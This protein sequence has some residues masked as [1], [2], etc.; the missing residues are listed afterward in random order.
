MRRFPITIM[1][2]FVSVEVSLGVEAANTFLVWTSMLLVVTPFM[3]T[4]SC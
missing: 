4:I 1:G 2:W 3:L